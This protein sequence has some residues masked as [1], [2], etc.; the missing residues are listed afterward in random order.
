MTTQVAFIAYPVTD[1]SA[2]RSFYDVVLG[3]SGSIVSDDWVE[4]VIGDTAFAI[5]QA[6]AD[7]PTPVR[8]ALAAFEVSDLTA[9]VTRLRERLVAFRG[10]IV[11]TPV[12]HFI[13]ALD[14]DGSEFLLHQRNVSPDPTRTI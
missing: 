2:S 12:C 14:P 11:E 1:I 6:D 8:G 5:S 3:T 9:E 7:H 4:Y 13:I 10:D